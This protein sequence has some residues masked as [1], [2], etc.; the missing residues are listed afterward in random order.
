MWYFLT[1]NDSLRGS[2]SINCIRS[3]QSIRLY[4]QPICFRVAI[5]VSGIKLLFVVFLITSITFDNWWIIE[6]RIRWSILIN[7][8]NYWVIKLEAYISNCP[9]TTLRTLTLKWL[10]HWI[11]DLI[12]T[13]NHIISWGRIINHNKHNYCLIIPTSLD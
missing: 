10:C 8:K 7:W 2:Y 12:I 11:I 3:V 4:S 6:T 5:E 9:R 1:R 13:G